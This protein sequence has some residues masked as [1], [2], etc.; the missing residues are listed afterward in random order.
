MKIV[1]I[2][3]IL[4]FCSSA[5]AA[6]ET[7]T[8]PAE[9]VTSG[10]NVIALP[11]FPVFLG[12]NPPGYPPD[13]LNGLVG[14]GTGLDGKLTRWD[15]E[16]QVTLAWDSTSPQ[17]K[18]DFGNLL[19]GDGYPLWISPTASPVTFDGVTGNDSVDTFIPLPKAGWTL[20]G[21]PYSVPTSTSG[22]PYYSGDPYLWE[23]VKVTDG[24]T[25]KS[26]RDAS[27]RGAR[28]IRST[29]IWWESPRQSLRTVGASQDFANCRSMIAW[30]G[31][32]VMSF[33]DNLGLIFEAPVPV[34]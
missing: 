22:P 29:A 10:W 9:A 32:W 21:Y 1:L 27:Q 7:V 12:G 24:L 4:V 25:T 33:K 26:L 14:G 5:F 3:L 28:W 8:A 19:L 34:E 13:V 23:N 30:H 2:I 11:A 17:A 16:R 20:I 15:A 31:Y 18:A 6:V